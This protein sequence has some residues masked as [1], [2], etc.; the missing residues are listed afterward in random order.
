VQQ[1]HV[2]PVRTVRRVNEDDVWVFLS[3]VNGFVMGEKEEVHM[4]YIVSGVPRRPVVVI[5]KLRD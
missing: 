1:R 3:K 4:A 2:V 5:E